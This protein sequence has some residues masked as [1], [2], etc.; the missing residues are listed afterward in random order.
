M[1]TVEL[2]ATDCVVPAGAQLRLSVRNHYLVKAAAAE[3]FRTLPL[4]V[5]ATFGVEHSSGMA[6]RLVLPLRSEPGL[7]VVTAAREILLS[8]PSPV[9]LQL[10]SSPLRAGAA[11]WVLGSLAGQGPAASLPGGNVVY[12]LVDALTAVLLDPNGN[13]LFPGFVGVLD[14]AGGASATMALAPVAPMPVALAGWHV[15]FAPVALHNGAAIAG[16]PLE[17]VFR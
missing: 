6:S 5:P 8:Q 7:D 1:V 4:F 17:L 11:Y 13:P 3:S 14:A 9:T 12:L 10:R 16:A 2:S 15:H